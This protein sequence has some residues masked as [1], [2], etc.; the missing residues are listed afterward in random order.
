MVIND[1]HPHKGGLL[2]RVAVIVG[3][4]D[5]PQQYPASGLRE[6]RRTVYVGRDHVGRGTS[7]QQSGTE[8]AGETEGTSRQTRLPVRFGLACCPV[9]TFDLGPTQQPRWKRT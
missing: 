9:N 3:W 6:I 8:S 5:R 7:K 1:K 4:Q 2:S